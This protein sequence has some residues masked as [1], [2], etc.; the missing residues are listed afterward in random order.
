VRAAP[1]DR[2]KAKLELFA[3]CIDPDFMRK[4]EKAA[5]DTVQKWMDAHRVAIAKLDE[6]RRA[7]Y[8][9][10]RNL[11]ASPELTSLVYPATLQGQQAKRIWD[12]H[13]YVTE[14]GGFAA[15]FTKPEIEALE[16]E[17]AAG[18]VIGWLRNIDRKP[19]ALCVPYEIDGE[20]RPMYPDFLIVR[21]EAG[22]PVVDIVDPHTISLADAPAKAA[23]LA[24]FAAEHANK[25]GRIELIMVDGKTSKRLELT[26]ESVR[27]KVRR[28]TLPT[29]LRQLFAEA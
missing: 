8:D 6:G 29:Q 27:N 2:D 22:N 21:S 15:D 13:L 24:K 14:K 1:A 16:R 7:A 10:I 4:I 3:L 17:L 5:Q 12:K 26:D 25:F 11:A 28:I 23:G 19:W 20:D 9:E 18:D